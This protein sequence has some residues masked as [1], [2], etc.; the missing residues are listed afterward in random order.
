M[1]E[2]LLS[3]IIPKAKWNQINDIM[4]ETP[5]FE[6]LSIETWKRMMDSVQKFTLS[7]GCE[8]EIKNNMRLLKKGLEKIGSNYLEN[9]KNKAA[10][11]WNVGLVTLIEQIY[12]I[13]EPD[14]KEHFTKQI[15]TLERIGVDTIALD[16]SIFY[17]GTLLGIA[18]SSIYPDK[19]HLVFDKVFTDGTFIIENSGGYSHL[20]NIKNLKDDNYHLSVELT[21]KEQ[22]VKLWKAKATL[23]SFNGEYPTKEEILAPRQP[24]L[25]FTNIDDET[26]ERFL[27]DKGLYLEYANFYANEHPEEPVEWQVT[28]RRVRQILK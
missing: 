25:S 14:K 15:E 18:T 13:N 7:D 8:D 9:G 23:S 11:F 21:S 10:H 3:E 5:L 27:R 17:T 4:R 28:N 2:Y 24:R 20:Y 1:D 6:G 19:T 16:T 26:L 12:A 22:Q